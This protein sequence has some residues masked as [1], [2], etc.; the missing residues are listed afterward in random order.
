MTKDQFERQDL[1]RIWLTL[2]ALSLHESPTLSVLEKATGI[3]MPTLQKVIARINSDQ[4]VETEVSLNDKVY[5]ISHWGVAKQDVC[6]R[7]YKN[8]CAMLGA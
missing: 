6:E 2:G 1:R 8:H 7:Y 5:S 3:G 4:M